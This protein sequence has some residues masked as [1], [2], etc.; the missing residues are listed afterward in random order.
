MRFPPVVVIVWLNAVGIF[1]T[2]LPPTFPD[3]IR[4]E[5]ISCKVDNFIKKMWSCFDITDLLIPTVVLHIT[6]KEKICTF[7]QENDNR[8]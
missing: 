8:W 4:H 3:Q 6:V 5:K 2:G 7:L 1:K